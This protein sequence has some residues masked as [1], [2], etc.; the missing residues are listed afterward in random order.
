[1]NMT[2]ISA[3]QI[4]DGF[5]LVGPGTVHI[6]D[7]RIVDV[8]TGQGT[9]PAGGDERVPFL[10]PGLVDAHVHASG[11]REGIPAGNPYGP[12]K[13][14]M[15]LC[16]SCGVTTVRDV[17]NSLE[18][19]YYFRDWN[20]RF[21]GPRIYGSGPLLDGT[22]FTWPFSRRVTDAN[23][24]CF[25]ATQ[26]INAGV[27][28]LKAYTNLEPALLETVVEVANAAG[29]PVAAHCGRTTAAQAASFGVRTIEHAEEL[30]SSLTA[31]EDGDGHVHDTIGRARQWATIDPTGEEVSAL[32]AVLIEHGTALCPTL[33]V[34]RRW[35]F[36]DEMTAEPANELMTPVMPYHAHF[37][38]AR[39]A[40]GTRFASKY[41]AR[42][43]PV[44]TLNRTERDEV[45]AG[46]EVMAATVR[47][48]AELG[49]AIVAGT[50]TPNPS[51]VPGHALHKE[52]LLLARA[53]FEPV[54][55]LRAATST[56]GDIIGDK[57]V[58]RIEPGAYADLIALTGDPTVD[59][60][61]LSQVT[62]VWKDG[63]ELDLDAVNDKVAHEVE[64]A[65]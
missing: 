6:A 16:V 53:G 63:V 38:H 51:V 31:H 33:L 1:M 52:L 23:Q 21:G 57:G 36:V 42:Y 45:T 61:Q 3:H 47:R 41:M 46:L 14:F 10:M 27:D 7:G 17:G 28:L 25:H 13:H 49:V 8:E 24:A 35:C 58:G 64:A 59:L 48:L 4:F 11:Y 20:K 50:D 2:S 26:L 12:V 34:S 62:R 56:A 22:P 55:V 40:I 18:T 54:E 43:M 9:L 19:L 39:G 65:R 37:R 60:R 5:R 32:A 30:L 15:R 29:L 44:R